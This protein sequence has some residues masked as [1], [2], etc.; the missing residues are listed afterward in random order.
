MGT[1]QKYEEKIFPLYI[2]NINKT[3]RDIGKAE[4]P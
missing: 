3:F 2:G 1:A 4:K